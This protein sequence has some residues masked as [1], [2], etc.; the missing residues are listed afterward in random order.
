MLIIF[1]LEFLLAIIVRTI[2]TCSLSKAHWD[3]GSSIYSGV[4]MDNKP[5]FKG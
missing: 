3:T 4:S 5:P 1:G 2:A